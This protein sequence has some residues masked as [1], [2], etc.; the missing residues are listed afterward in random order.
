MNT[1]DTIQ[2]SVYAAS[3]LLLAVAPSATAQVS[4]YFR[5]PSGDWTNTASWDTGLPGAGT[6]A[7][8]GY[9]AAGK[10]NP[11]T[12]FIRS[13]DSCVAGNL[14]L[15]RG[16][17]T[18]TGTLIMDGG[19]LTTVTNLYL[20]YDG[21]TGIIVQTGGALSHSA[22]GVCNNIGGGFGSWTISGMGTIASNGNVGFWLPY[23]GARAELAI[24]NGGAMVGGAISIGGAGGSS[25]TMTIAAGGSYRAPSGDMSV[26]GGAGIGVLVVSNGI[27][28]LSP[29]ALLIGYA[30]TWATGRVT[31][32]DA[33]ATLTNVIMARSGG[34]A[35]LT[36]GGATVVTNC[37]YLQV[38]QAYG[39][40]AVFTM[41][42]GRWWQGGTFGV[43]ANGTA[44]GLAT[45]AG[46]EFMPQG[47]VSVGSGNTGFR[48]TL[49]VSNTTVTIPGT[50]TVGDIGHGEFNVINGVLDIGGSVALGAHNGG[51]GVWNMTDA[52]ITT[53][54]V[55]GMSSGGSVVNTS[56]VFQVR[57]QWV[58]QTNVN[59]N[60][61]V[62]G[63]GNLACY[64]LSNGVFRQTAG[65]FA[66]GSS[67]T[68]GRVELVGTQR[69][70]QTTA[71]DVRGRGSFTNRIARCAGG[72]DITV[73]NASALSIASNGVVALVF[74]RNPAVT[75]MYWGLRWL[76]ANHVA[77]LNALHSS[78]PPRLV[79]D[80]SALSSV[81]RNQVGIYTGA[82]AGVDYT[83]V[84]IRVD[85]VFGNNGAVV[86]IR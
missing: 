30:G 40:T 81:Y 2:R 7:Y 32:V 28:D 65:A 45:I 44:T 4:T 33:E 42:G 21:G 43:G 84:G 58:A 73:T 67:V 22:F 54:A 69:V 79:W 78:E 14:S 59:L 47:N 48:G 56:R 72:I 9:A 13:G 61:S 36:V 37:G 86:V 63:G 39:G 71:L 3:I 31:F 27:L 29:R 6:S 38:G 62:N 80:D 15:G 53:R 85:R 50:V 46:G 24:S 1:M 35:S 51:L 19:L 76:G 57:G 74:E 41:T 34:D 20:A 66:V 55:V 82:E 11:A 16:N 12:A 52:A 23:R 70:F 8:I 83:Y 64:W 77:T 68:T 10:T 26:G 25:G 60:T 75:G 5:T 17:A 49:T 18:G